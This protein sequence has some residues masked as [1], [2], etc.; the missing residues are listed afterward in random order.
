[1]TPTAHSILVVDDDPAIHQLLAAVLNSDQWR[2]ESAHDGLEG[3]S[4]VREKAFDLVLTDVRMPGM[5]GLELLRRIRELRPQ[6]KVVVMT[7]ESTPDNIISSL[8]DQAFSYF[9]KPFSP[10]AVVEMVN[11]ALSTPAWKDDIEVVSARPEWIALQVRC[12]AENADRLLPFLREIRMDLPVQQ[13]DDI[14]S[15]FREMLLNAIEHGGRCDPREKVH[16]ACIRTRRMIIYHL[17]DPGEGFSIDRLPHAAVS[18]P[19]EDPAKHILYR[20]EQ[21]MR[22]GGFGILLVRELVDELIYNEKGNEVILIKYL[23]P[24]EEQE[25]A[26]S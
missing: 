4:R 10:A 6:T 9:S 11:E 3:L 18:N 21:G 19:P 14:A 15:A 2:I 24:R 7:A 17:R 20:T 22:P 13:Q 8:R 23:N 16:V 25:S 12:K 5:N 1:M 26:Q